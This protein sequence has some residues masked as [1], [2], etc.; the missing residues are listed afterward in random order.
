MS[1]TQW[2][3]PGGGENT[4]SWRHR[5][6]VA[7]FES[8]QVTEAMAQAEMFEQ[9]ARWWDDSLCVFRHAMGEL[10]AQAW[11]STGGAAAGSMVD[12][13]V[14]QAR[15]LSVALEKVPELVRTAAE[16]IV[17]TKYAI[18]PLI[19][20]EAGAS[21]Q[22]N[23]A[24]GAD[25]A[26]SV[27]DSVDDADSAAAHG[28]ASAAEEN[29]RAEMRQRYVVP[30]GELI[31]RIPLLPMPT[32]RIGAVGEPG[33]RRLL[34]EGCGAVEP[35][36]ATAESGGRATR[37]AVDATAESTG[38]EGGEADG[39]GLRGGGT[40]PASAAPDHVMADGMGQPVSAVSA[41]A[42]SGTTGGVASPGRAGVSSPAGAGISVPGGAGISVPGGAGSLTA[43]WR[44]S[45]VFSGDP[46]TASAGRSSPTSP[47]AGLSWTAGDTG[48]RSS[49]GPRYQPT[50]QHD[51]QRPGIVGHS[52]PGSAGSAI[53]ANSPAGHTAT[54]SVDR[55]FHCAGAPQTLPAPAED[56][57]RGLPAYL[58]TSANTA[59]LLGEPRPAIAGGVIG[60]DELVRDEQ[61]SRSATRC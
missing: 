42:A 30:F 34:V 35:V 40:S 18:P 11:S 21:A 44:N 23:R 24:V 57:A 43:P 33:D 45:P 52:V 6:I 53:G 2:R 22:A 50:G 36:G 13:Y 54:R 15:D 41:P 17:A 58:I 27:S 1:A 5:E 25:S 59:E 32:R 10:L 48:D 47:Y 19:A 49:S 51:A 4:H 7:A 55:Y 3:V 28:A 16:A 26:W 20:A 12:T 29:A 60:A 8:L 38:L 61:R 31:E 56:A 37:L 9:I 14:T 39:A 46:A